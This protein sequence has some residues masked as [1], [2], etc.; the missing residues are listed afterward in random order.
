MATSEHEITSE[1][2]GLKGRIGGWYL[3]SPLRRVSELFFLGDL[4]GR[5]IEKIDTLLKGDETV[6]DVGGGSGYFSLPIAQRLSNG[7]VIS[8]DLSEEMQ[9]ELKRKAKARNLTP[10]IEAQLGNAYQLD[11]QDATIDVATSNGVFHELSE[12]KKAL[13]EIKRVLR[14]GGFVI[15][16]DFRDT[17]IGKRIGA[18]HNAEDHGPFSPEE[19]KALI[20]DAGFVN[21]T[22]ETIKNWVLGMGQKR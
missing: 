15:L 11:V 1:W 10:R 22:V 12:P 3:N 14:P 17:P 19:L 4:K 5:F 16:T 13:A 2:A 18:A 9:G 8:L 20:A 6:L 21:V 7:K